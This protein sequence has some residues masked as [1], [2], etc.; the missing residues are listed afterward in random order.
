M[1]G[2]LMPWAVAML[3]MMVWSQ[4]AQAGGI[5]FRVSL[6]GAAEIATLGLSG[7][8]ASGLVIDKG[9]PA[10]ADTLPVWCRRWCCYR[11]Y[12]FY[13]AWCYYY[14]PVYTYRFY[15][16]PPV[17]YYYWSGPVFYFFPIGGASGATFSLSIGAGSMAAVPPTSPAPNERPYRYDIVP[18]APPGDGTYRYDGGP[19]NP[20]PM[21]PGTNPKP[22]T[23]PAPPSTVPF[24]GRAVSIPAK[25]KTSP[26]SYR[27]YGELPTAPPVVPSTAPSVLV[28]QR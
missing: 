5:N 18:Y 21:P 8:A 20:V 26:Y 14:P 4:P 19:Q 16:A 13:P 2:K 15:Y 24:E 28:R 3:G 1:L 12:C 9:D 23:D 10:N 22:T 11:P 27:A 6:N 25:P 7:G 17:Y